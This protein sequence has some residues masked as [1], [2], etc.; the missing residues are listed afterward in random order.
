MTPT[1]PSKAAER[2]VSELFPDKPSNVKLRHRATTIIDREMQ[3]LREAAENFLCEVERQP[4]ALWR[5][6]GPKLD[7]LR[8]ALADESVAPRNDG[9]SDLLHTI[10]MLVL[11]RRGYDDCRELKRAVD[12]AIAYRTAL[13]ME[14]A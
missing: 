13:E 2:I 7:A 1:P 9:L 4:E 12:D 3:S 5:V 6:R 11:Q 14:K 10:S 8:T